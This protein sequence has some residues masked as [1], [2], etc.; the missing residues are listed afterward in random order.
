MYTF[1]GKL[2]IL[3]TGA[4]H[5]ITILSVSRFCIDERKHKQVHVNVG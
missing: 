2:A 3:L 4:K 5:F 1:N